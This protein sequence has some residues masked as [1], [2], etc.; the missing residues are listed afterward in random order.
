MTAPELAAALERGA[1]VLDLRQPR[2][3]AAGHVPGAVNLQFN[4]ADL[5]ERTELVL[6]RELE[7]VVHAEPEAIAVVAWKI[8]QQARFNVAGQ[9]AGGLRGWETERR[10]V[11]RMRVIDVDELR[12]GL[13]SY[14]VIDAREGYE[15]RSG[16]IAGAILLPSGEAWT[17]AKAL[18]SGRPLAVVCGDQ[19]RSSLV[20]SIL[21]RVGRQ[22]VLVIGGMVDWLEHGYPIEKAL[23]SEPDRRI[24]I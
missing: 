8:L 10:A 2:H 18:N 5:A 1:V 21:L 13:D 9:L 4:R 20:A 15:Y 22:A 3:F 17:K 19:V 11:E 14:Q 24:R 16:H 23:P 7:Y 6:P 12:T